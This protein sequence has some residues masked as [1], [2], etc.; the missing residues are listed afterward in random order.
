MTTYGK[1]GKG[2]DATGLCSLALTLEV[3]GERWTFLI[4]REA[5]A[6]TTRFSEFRSAL[7]VSTDILAARLAT[8]TDAGIL[9]R[10]RYQERGQRTR[11]EYK[12]TD[13]GRE[14]ALALAALQQWGDEHLPSSVPTISYQDVQGRPLRVAFIDETGCP[15]D[16]DN[17]HA[18]RP[19][20]QETLPT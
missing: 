10:E 9:R 1:N 16:H 14:L 17:V 12:F 11:D 3:V 15:V 7:G 20:A 5:L 2:L 13:S 8:L 19:R 4:L 6:G 18:C